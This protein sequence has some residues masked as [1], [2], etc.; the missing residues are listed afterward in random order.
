ME[1]P[2]TSPRTS[3]GNVIESHWTQDLDGNII[4]T[5]GQIQSLPSDAGTAD[6]E[7][8]ESVPLPPDTTPP[9][10]PLRRTAQLPSTSSSG[11]PSGRNSRMGSLP[12]IPESESSEENALLKEPS[13]SHWSRTRSQTIPAEAHVRRLRSLMSQ[14]QS[15]RSSPPSR[16]FPEQ[17]LSSSPLPAS[18][19]DSQHTDMSNKMHTFSPFR[20][21]SSNGTHRGSSLTPRMHHGMPFEPQSTSSPPRSM[22]RSPPE[23]R[24]PLGACDQR[25][26]SVS[27]S[28]PP[29]G[30]AD[31]LPPRQSPVAPQGS[32]STNHLSHPYPELHHQAQYTQVPVNL[33][34]LWD[35]GS[36]AQHESLFDSRHQP[37]TS[38]EN[39][40]SRE[41]LQTH[42]GSAIS[43]PSHVSPPPQWPGYEIPNP[44]PCPEGQTPYPVA[45]TI[46]DGYAWDGY[47]WQPVSKP[48]NP[49]ET[50]PVRRDCTKGSDLQASKEKQRQE[51]PAAS[52]RPPLT[53]CQ[54]QHGVSTGSTLPEDASESMQRRLDAL[55]RSVIHDHWTNLDLYFKRQTDPAFLAFVEPHTSVSSRIRRLL[56]KLLK[57]LAG[58]LAEHTKLQTGSEHWHGSWRNQLS[59]LDRTMQTFCQFSSVVCNREPSFRML[60]KVLAKLN[61]Y[62]AKFR[63]L[64][65][66]IYVRTSAFSPIPLCRLF[67]LTTRYASPQTLLNRLRLRAVHSDLVKAHTKAQEQLRIAGSRRDLPRWDEDKRHR[68]NLRGDFISLQNRLALS[69]R[70]S[71]AL[72]QTSSN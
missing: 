19:Q 68:A 8:L 23:N 53:P 40:Q 14:P 61:Q 31:A 10:P 58:A 1:T 6:L 5:M 43:I 9:P 28:H 21:S 49:E 27:K 48:K 30:P 3:Y 4:S 2:S 17:P 55:H 24:P 42:Q 67:R 56:D 54:A 45:E 37:M 72:S 26:N 20:S 44:H 33:P 71:W 57:F 11:G 63:D 34:H 51:V 64:T 66:K 32:V 12:I 22:S 47:A 69:R 41:P 18:P 39:H 25:S 70:P 16:V 15:Q 38:S 50:G 59:S 36:N 35:P 62:E 7:N 52:S 29:R 13:G 65:K 46:G 60:D